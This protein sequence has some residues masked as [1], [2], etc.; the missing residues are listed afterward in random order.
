MSGELKESDW[1]VLRQ[2]HPIALER[3]CRRAL[4]EIEQVASAADRS[5]HERYLDV[6]RLVDRRRREMADA[7]NDMRRSR[8]LQRLTCIQ[9]HELLTEEELGRFSPEMREALRFMLD[10]NGT[11]SAGRP[12]G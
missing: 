7:F 5:C 10:M 6:L 8:A 9:S 3:F 4:D 12:A 1:K 2:L 11:G